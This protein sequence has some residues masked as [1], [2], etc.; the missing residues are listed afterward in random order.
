[1]DFEVFRPILLRP[2]RQSGPSRLGRSP[3]C[4]VLK[5]RMLVLLSQAERKTGWMLSE[6]AGHAVLGSIPDTG[7]KLLMLSLFSPSIFPVSREGTR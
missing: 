3:V 6:A 1:M 7:I 2:L 5:F 4:P